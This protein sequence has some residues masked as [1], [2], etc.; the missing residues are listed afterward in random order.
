[1]TSYRTTWAK[2]LQVDLKNG[3]FTMA[4]I[5]CMDSTNDNAL[6]QESIQTWIGF[7]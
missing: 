5:V 1:M 2:R 6:E 4:L 7:I 3:T